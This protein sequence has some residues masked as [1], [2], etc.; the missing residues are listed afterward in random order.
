MRSI[1]LLSS[2]GRTLSELGLTT[3][4]L[5][6]DS[7][8]GAAGD[9]GLGVRENGGDRETTR[10]LN[11]HKERSGSSNKGLELVLLEL[12]LL[13]GVKEILS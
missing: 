6:K 10:A 9:N 11:V 1:D 8:A 12:G 5:G 2:E 7:G 13:G 3:S 4:G